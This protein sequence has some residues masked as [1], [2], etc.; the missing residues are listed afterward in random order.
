RVGV[1]AAQAEAVAVEFG[2]GGGREG[3]GRRG[4]PVGVGHAAIQ[5]GGAAR[6]TGIPSR[7]QTVRAAP[8]RRPDPSYGAAPVSGAPA[9]EVRRAASWAGPR[10][11][12]ECR[13]GRGP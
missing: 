12:P 13:P 1:P 6:N 11:S 4:P 3:A 8:D 7:K 10:G 5:A 2:A 9:G